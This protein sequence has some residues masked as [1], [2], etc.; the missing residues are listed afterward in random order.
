MKCKVYNFLKMKQSTSKSKN[1]I[2]KICHLDRDRYKVKILEKS[3]LKKMRVLMIFKGRKTMEKRPI[4]IVRT[5]KVLY[6]I[7]IKF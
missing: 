4:K 5:S 3:M 1:K 6:N 2:I 7:N